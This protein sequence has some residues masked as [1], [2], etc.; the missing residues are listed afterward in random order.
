[1]HRRFTSLDRPLDWAY[2]S[3]RQIVL[4]GGGFLLAAL[5]FQALWLGRVEFWTALWG[6]GWVFAT[7]ALGRELDPDHP[8]SAFWAALALALGLLLRP[9]EWTRQGLLGDLLVTGVLMLATRVTARTSGRRTTYPDQFVLAASPAAAAWLSG[10]SLWPLAVPVALALVLDARGDKNRRRLVFGLILA[11][12]GGLLAWQLGGGRLP[13]IWPGGFSLLLVGLGVVG[14]GLRAR[15]PAL[16]SADD[17]GPLEPRR[18]TWARVVGIVG[19]LTGLVLIGASP[20]LP[21]GWVGLLMLIPSL[22]AKPPGPG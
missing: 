1:M 12:V 15:E 7:W 17:N 11:L 14:L 18:V 8:A 5:A 3:N 2:P 21:V 6:A 10:S 13:E 19:T 4:L 20:F 16:S 9:A 22:R